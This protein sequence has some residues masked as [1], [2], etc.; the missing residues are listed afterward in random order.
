MLPDARSL[1][2]LD[3]PDEMTARRIVALLVSAG[4]ASSEAA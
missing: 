4:G 3:A 1:D 2:D